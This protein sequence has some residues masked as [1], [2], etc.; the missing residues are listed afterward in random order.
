MCPCIPLANTNHLS[1]SGPAREAQRRT[2][3]SLSIAAKAV[4]IGKQA[5]ESGTLP[6]VKTLEE[7]N[8][9]MGQAEKSL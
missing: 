4:T 5:R 7:D 3:A 9:A 1:G 6:Q 2:Q 8:G